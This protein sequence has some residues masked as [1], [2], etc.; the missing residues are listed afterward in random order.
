MSRRPLDEVSFAELRLWCLR[1]LAQHPHLAPRVD[2][3]LFIGPGVSW[4]IFAAIRDLV[5]RGE[6]VTPSRVYVECGGDHLVGLGLVDV[7]WPT[8]A[9][10]ERTARMYLCRLAMNA[11]QEVDRDAA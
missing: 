7:F 10:N 3:T 5:E 2:G 4:P 11:N 6:A 1:S 9:I 8:P